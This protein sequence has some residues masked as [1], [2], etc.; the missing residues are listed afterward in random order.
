MYG[1]KV[2]ASLDIGT[3]STLFLL[4]KLDASG[5]IH[6]VQHEVRTNDLGRGTGADGNL[7][8]E[9]IELNLRLL[10]DFKQVAEDA[11][12]EEIRIAATEALRRAS[13]ADLLIKRAEKE[14]GLQIKVISGKEEA[15][16]TYRGI[17]SGLDDPGIKLLAADIGGGSSEIIYGVGQRIHYSTSLS[18]GAVSL[19]R[20]TI[21]NDPPTPE[22]LDGV[23]RKSEA[24]LADIPSLCSKS[25]RPTAFFF[26]FSPNWAINI[27][28]FS[29]SFI[30]T[31]CFFKISTILSM[32]KAIPT[33][34]VFGPP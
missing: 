16:L 13:N 23:R 5:K 10:R 17:L 11:G 6:P 26:A 34:G 9:I 28:G 1:E 22:E 14:L 33:A 20:E 4:A 27:W 29:V 7:S 3:N 15:A 24:A 12:A 18:V 8:P 30:W 31:F 25:N 32:P 21:R 19:D 2:L